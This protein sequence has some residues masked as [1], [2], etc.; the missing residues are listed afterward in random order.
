[1]IYIITGIAHLQKLGVDIGDLDG[2][3]KKALPYLEVGMSLDKKDLL[4]SW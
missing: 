3:V 2:V 4:G 1:M